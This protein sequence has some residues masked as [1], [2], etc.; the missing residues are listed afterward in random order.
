MTNRGRPKGSR[1][2]EKPENLK[3]LAIYLAKVKRETNT[4]PD[5]AKAE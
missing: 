1:N 2:K 3:K 4:K 5:Q